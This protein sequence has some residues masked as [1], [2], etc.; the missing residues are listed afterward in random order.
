MSFY[1]VK[2]VLSQDEQ[3]VKIIACPI[4]SEKREKENNKLSG[5]FAIVWQNMNELKY[6]KVRSN[7]LEREKLYGSKCQ[8]G[9]PI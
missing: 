9:V 3:D 6:M 2:D 7:Q 5:A 4:F 8:P 1:F